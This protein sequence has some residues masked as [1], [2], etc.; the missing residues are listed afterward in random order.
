MAGTVVEGAGVT[1][2]RDVSDGVVF[3]EADA[4]SGV[5]QL[6]DLLDRFASLKGRQDLVLIVHNGDR[7]PAADVLGEWATRVRQVFCV[8]VLD[9]I[10]GVTPIPI[11]LENAWRNRNGRL[12]YYLD[13]LKRPVKADDYD[14]VVVSSFSVDTNRA[15]REPVA[16]LLASS[17]HG[18]QGMVWKSGEFRDVISRSLFV[19]CPPGNGADTHR[20]WESLYLGAI[21]VVERASLAPSLTDH[22]P[23]FVVDSYEEFLDLS[24]DELRAT[25]V[26]MRQR[27]TTM[28]YAPYWASRISREAGV[29]GG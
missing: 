13:R 7:V 19:I 20:T 10:D 16:A 1:V 8:N 14:H 24:D 3:V 9:D 15:K 18:H 21:P 12:R 22:L 4:V 26:T 11:G 29:F 23:I 6:D 27:P 2:Q 25:Y 17:R 5:D 28:A